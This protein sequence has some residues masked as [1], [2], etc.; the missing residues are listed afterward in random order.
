MKLQTE[1]D[2]PSV[3]ASTSLST[4]FALVNH[5]EIRGSKGGKEEPRHIMDTGIT[6]KGRPWE[7]L[8]N[9]PS[10]VAFQHMGSLVPQHHR[11]TFTGKHD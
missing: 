1:L 6:G 8:P 3:V 4:P 10:H 9:I 7:N 2:V 5:C 11:F